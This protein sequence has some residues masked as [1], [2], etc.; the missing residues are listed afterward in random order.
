[1]RRLGVEDRQHRHLAGQSQRRPPLC[2]LQL[3]GQFLR[4]ADV[5]P[6]EFDLMP[7]GQEARPDRVAHTSRCP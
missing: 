1:V 4:V 6:D 7:T 2:S 3:V 5:R